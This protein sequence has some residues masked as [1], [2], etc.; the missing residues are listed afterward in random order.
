MRAL[1]FPAEGSCSVW[2]I[3]VYSC[4]LRVAGDLT[5][6]T[7]IRAL[8]HTHVHTHTHWPL[9][10]VLIANTGIHKQQRLRMKQS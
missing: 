3:P 8:T 9:M 6:R 5:G 4:L 10:T 7:L 1:E 2:F